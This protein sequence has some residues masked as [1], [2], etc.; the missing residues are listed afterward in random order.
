MIQE[1]KDYYELLIP[2]LRLCVSLGCS[3]EEKSTPQPID[4]D[5]KINYLEEPIGCHSDK[6]VDVICYHTLTEKI[7][8]SVQNRSFNLIEFL[9]KYIFETVSKHIDSKGSIVEIAITKLNHPV[10]H[11]QKGIVFK[12]CRR[13]PQNSL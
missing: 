5:I 10:Q 11:V 6:L 2:G 4:I 9:A 12:Y 7:I 8:E 1:R 13:L 3:E